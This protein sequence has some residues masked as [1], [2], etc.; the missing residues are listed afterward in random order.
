MDPSPLDLLPQTKPLPR[1]PNLD[2]YRKQAKDLVKAL[3]TGDPVAI[4]F[5]KDYHPRF[6]C[7]SA[8]EVHRAEPAL[9][10][11][12]FTI[13][14]QYG[15]DS[16]PKFARHIE[17]LS[18]GGSSVAA[19]EAA[20]DAVV[21]GD[22]AALARLL[23]D[24][25]ELI[26][27]RSNRAHRATLLHYVS[28]NGVEEFRR[29]TPP[30]VA[31]VA[32]LLLDAGAEVDATIQRSETNLGAFAVFKGENVTRWF[33]VD[34][35]PA[36][37]S[38]TTLGLVATN[39]RLGRTIS[40]GLLTV[41]LDR[42]ASIDG[43]AGGPVIV[44]ACLALGCRD[45]AELLAKRGARLDLQAAAG[46][47]RL[48]RVEA[49]LGDGSGRNDAIQRQTERGFRWA[50]LYGRTAVVD[51]LLRR[52]VTTSSAA[53]GPSRAM[54]IPWPSI[55]LHEAVMGGH[56]E[57]VKRLLDHQR[58][59]P[60]DRAH[61]A[62]AWLLKFAVWRATRDAESDGDATDRDWLG[63]IE[64]LLEAGAGVEQGNGPTGNARV[65]D[66]LA[67]FGIKKKTS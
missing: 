41:L 12:Q 44:D 28:A 67:R 13:A 56:L 19:F 45:A 6:D 4:R 10:D 57:T 40:D 59:A 35:S 51:F 50:C 1:H 29:R 62:N 32:A 30:N 55:G 9:A 58:A 20:A 23:C 3:D 66:L 49:L 65:D 16:W 31:A 14:R 18:R 25:P 36:V 17:Q 33:G 24:S 11:A 8:E 52:G 53:A 7:L 21:A 47:G 48:D 61:Q 15:F 37:G 60:A 2:Q 63:I 46:V 43:V 64:A 26:R 22:V 27:S 54:P 5:L 39:A 34:F 42:G 38:Y